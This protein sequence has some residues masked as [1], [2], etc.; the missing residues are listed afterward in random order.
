MHALHHYYDLVAVLLAKEIKI[1]YKNTALGWLWSILQPM[2]MALVFFFVLKT[3]ARFSVEEYPLILIT[4]LFPWQ[5]FQNSITA[6]TGVFINNGSLIKKVVFPRWML[7]LA[8]GL[9]DGVHFL[10]SL[11]VI[12]VALLYFRHMPTWHWLY[13]MP[14][15]F[16]IQLLMTLGIAQLAGTLNVFFRD[17]ERIVVVG[18]MMWMYLSPVIFPYD[19][20]TPAV[21][22]KLDWNPVTWL[23]RGWRLTFMEGYCPPRILLIALAWALG[24]FI[25]G[26]AVQYRYQWRL[27]EIV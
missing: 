20:L 14:S 8:V 2:A 24:L 17:L 27:A 21:Q 3:V 22:A 15:L 13:L 19:A 9:N 26:Q 18:L 23:I 6:S 16:M 25:L 11:P 12:F 10:L 7:V 5:W 4:G 1:R